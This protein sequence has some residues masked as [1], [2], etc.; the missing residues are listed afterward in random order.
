VSV[1]TMHS[2]SSTDGR[3]TVTVPDGKMKA[4][5]LAAPGNGA[6]A[7]S[8]IFG[9]STPSASGARFGV[10]YADAAPGYLIAHGVDATLVEAE[11]TNLA[12]L[13]GTLV[14]SVMTTVAGQP[15]RDDRIAVGE[16]VY[17]FRTVFLGGRMY[18]ISVTGSASQVDSADA[19]VFLD[20]F[21][22]P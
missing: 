5:S 1:S 16:V 18:S 6:F 20:S 14:S 11:Q 8:P 4:S 19:K 12:S 3:F 15:A 10:L 2:F 13:N 17:V 21:T 7:G 9:F 22:S